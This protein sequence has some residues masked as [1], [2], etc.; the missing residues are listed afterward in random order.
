[1]VVYRRLWHASFSFSLDYLYRATRVK[2]EGNLA[3]DIARWRAQLGGGLQWL[4]SWSLV[5][6]QIPCCHQTTHGLSHGE[7]YAQISDTA[8]DPTTVNKL[9]QTSDL[10]NPRM[11]STTESCS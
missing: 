7:G 2:H 1:M 11:H 8:E 4:L 6:Q 5:D 3:T 9:Q 10:E